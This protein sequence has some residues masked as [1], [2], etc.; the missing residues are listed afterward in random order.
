MTNH[1]VCGWVHGDDCAY[2]LVAAV[3]SVDGGSGGDGMSASGAICQSDKKSY[4]QT[5]CAHAVNEAERQNASSCSSCV[6]CVRSMQMQMQRPQ[7]GC[8]PHSADMLDQIRCARTPSWHTQPG[9]DAD[10]TSVGRHE[11]W[12]GAGGISGNSPLSPQIKGTGVAGSH[13][14]GPVVCRD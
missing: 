6:V 13:L 8:I 5:L 1:S 10:V 7:T 11:F 2:A 14:F 12:V 4:L 3:C 9:A